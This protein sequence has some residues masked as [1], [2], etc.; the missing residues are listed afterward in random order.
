M[1]KRDVA[2]LNSGF[3]HNSSISSINNNMQSYYIRSATA[4]YLL[5]ALSHFATA[6]IISDDKRVNG[7]QL[8]YFFDDTKADAC[9]TLVLVGVGTAMKTTQYDLVST[10]MVQ[11]KPVVTIITDHTPRWFVKLSEKGYAK[12]ANTIVADL[13]QIVPEACASNKPKKII[14]GGHSA[15]GSAAWKSLKY[16][17]FEPDAFI[18]LDPFELSPDDSFVLPSLNFGFT[19]TTC[20]VTTTGAGQAGYQA[21]E[22][23]HRVFYQIDNSAGSSLGHCSFTDTGCFG[24]ICPAHEG[25]E[26]VRESVGEALTAFVQSLASGVYDRKQYEL[27]NTEEPLNLYVNKDKVNAQREA[28]TTRKLRNGF[29]PQ[30]ATA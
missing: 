9:D 25:S 4:L 27:N 20:A 13:A 26:F 14:I 10:Q 1:N 17:D 29:R 23:D 15:S 18:G 7:G 30:L 11:G 2:L 6:E 5:L 12:L 16:L 22:E 24:S 28:T 19:Q 3:A 21:S 8:R